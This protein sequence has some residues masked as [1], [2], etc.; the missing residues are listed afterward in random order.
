MLYFCI[1]SRV[2]NKR[3]R[4]ATSLKADEADQEKRARV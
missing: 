3:R 4:T 1:C 2:V